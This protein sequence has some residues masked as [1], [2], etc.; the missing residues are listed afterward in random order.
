LD[1]YG[2]ILIA[3]GQFD[4]GV[5]QLQKAFMVSKNSEIRYHLAYG[6][7]KQGKNEEARSH[8]SELLS[9]EMLSAN[10]E[11]QVKAL[12]KILLEK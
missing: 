8:V 11:K 7:E 2:W 6:L 3:N 4:R 5:E 10:L 12:Q 1:T 9:D